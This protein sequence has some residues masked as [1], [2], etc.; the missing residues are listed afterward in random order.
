MPVLRQGLDIPERGSPEV[1]PSGHGDGDEIMIEGLPPKVAPMGDSG[2][3]DLV[4]EDG[5]KSR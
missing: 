3:P 5:R 1:P 2:C 4:A